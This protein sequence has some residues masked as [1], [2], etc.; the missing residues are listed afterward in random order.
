M[1]Y[2]Y[3]NYKYV[4][5]YA[6]KYSRWIPKFSVDNQPGIYPNN[7][8]VRYTAQ[9]TKSYNWVLKLNLHFICFLFW[10]LLIY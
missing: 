4:S 5:K 8:D 9:K 6:K 10:F 3:F 1:N 7:S 2:K